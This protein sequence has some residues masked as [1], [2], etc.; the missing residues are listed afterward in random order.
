[1][2]DILEAAARE[3][4]AVLNKY[5]RK[6]YYTSHKDTPRNI[7]TQADIESQQVICDTIVDL[8]VKKGHKKSD[9]GF[10]GEENLH[11]VKKHTFIIDPLDGTT[12]FSVGIP[13]FCIPIAYVN[14]GKTEASIVYSPIDD[15]MYIAK[16]GK[17]AYKKTNSQEEKLECIYKPIDKVVASAHLSA[18]PDNKEKM[19]KI[20]GQLQTATLGIRHIGVVALE[21]CWFAENILGI[22]INSRN[23]IWDTAA[24]QLI[25]KESGGT[26]V[27]FK[28]AE[29]TYDFSNPMKT[30]NSLAVHPKNLPSILKYF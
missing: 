1:M 6:I 27:D 3:G 26:L 7:V 13:L 15:I 19:L 20:V 12:N 17:G 9:I 29:M 30:Y 16:R 24:T 25:I 8:M 14:N 11:S 18:H 21:Q 28:G 5:F 2:L 23:Y 4:G 22:V 10:I